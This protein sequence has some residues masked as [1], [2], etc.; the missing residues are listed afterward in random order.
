[1]DR[2]QH[3]RSPWI[4]HKQDHLSVFECVL[5][6]SFREFFG[7]LLKQAQ[8]P[9]PPALQL[10]QKFTNSS[11]ILRKRPGCAIG[12]TENISVSIEISLTISHQCRWMSKRELKDF[13]WKLRIPEFCTRMGAVFTK[14]NVRHKV[15]LGKASKAPVNPA[16]KSPSVCPTVNESASSPIKYISPIILKTF[17]PA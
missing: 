1:M 16:A 12:N 5:P 14:P 11:E 2:R 13:T 7:S 8:L 4:S 6:S 17:V 10:I 15:T 9:Y 3:Y